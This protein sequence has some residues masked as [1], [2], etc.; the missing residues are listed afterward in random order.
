MWTAPAPARVI[1]ARRRGTGGGARKAARV[2]RA[3]AA[4]MG[5]RWGAGALRERK[6]NATATA[7]AAACSPAT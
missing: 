7:R 3:P 1:A 6:V 4:A 5:S 2:A